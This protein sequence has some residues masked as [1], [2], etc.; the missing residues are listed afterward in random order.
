MLDGFLQDIGRVCDSTTTSG[1]LPQQQLMLFAE[2]SR[3]KA[4]VTS[5]PKQDYKISEADCGQSSLAL[6]AKFDRD[7]LSW[8]TCQQSP[9]EDC[10]EFSETLP[11]SGTMRNGK[12]FQRPPLVQSTSV[13]GSLLWP[14]LKAKEDGRSPE[15]WAKAR[16]RGYEV[17][18]AKGTSSGGPA[19]EKG[20]LAVYLRTIEG[21]SNGIVNPQWAEWYMGFPERWTETND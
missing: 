6:L 10:C 4:S 1:H 2:G 17:R 14:T 13:R 8:K 19:S 7:S 16:L 5:D 20:S 11:R 21:V 15:A 18:K 9:N 3:A 12:L